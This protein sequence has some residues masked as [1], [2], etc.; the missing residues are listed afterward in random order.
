MRELGD[1]LPGYVD[2]WSQFDS[3]YEA[4]L[5]AAFGGPIEWASLKG[6]VTGYLPETLV[7]AATA[8]YQMEVSPGEAVALMV[9][10]QAY[11]FNE[12]H[13]FISRILRPSLRALMRDHDSMLA[14]VSPLVIH[15]VP[16]KTT[17]TVKEILAVFVERNVAS[18]QAPL[19]Q[20]PILNA[21][22][23]RMTHHLKQGS[24]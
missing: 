12:N 24:P 2:Y 5:I 22:A 14:A 7:D 19:R 16:N 4:T 3:I 23:E 18:A 13:G 20:Q 15:G 21:F 6:S 10:L 1:N 8:G 17:A 11:A 9:I